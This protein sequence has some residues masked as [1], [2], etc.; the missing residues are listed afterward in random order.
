MLERCCVGTGDI[1]NLVSDR[2]DRRGHV[3]GVEIV[4]VLERMAGNVL[5]V[6]DKPATHRAYAQPLEVFPEDL[7][8][9]QVKRQPR[10]PR[11]VQLVTVPISLQYGV[12]DWPTRHIRPTNNRHRGPVPLKINP[13]FV[14]EVANTDAKTAVSSRHHKAIHH[15]QALARLVGE[16]PIC[17]ADYFRARSCCDV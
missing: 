7:C 12:I 13:V 9:G 11:T 2:Q 17:L 6:D 10:S 15:Q 3:N 1:F 14:V 8:F 4:C 16:R 5:P